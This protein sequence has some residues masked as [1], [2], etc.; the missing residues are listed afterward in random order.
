MPTTT[1]IL[2]FIS[3]F[4]AVSTLMCIMCIK[5]NQ[6]RISEDRR[7]YQ[8]HI[9]DLTAAL[10]P[11]HNNHISTNPTVPDTQPSDIQYTEV[12]KR[13]MV[14]DIRTYFNQRKNNAAIAKIP[15]PD[16][17]APVN[18]YTHAGSYDERTLYYL[19][20]GS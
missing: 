9:A 18:P 7:Q 5:R 12:E 17:L 11:T 2:I 6:Q 8:Q 10:F 1:H 20:R 4:L 15:G 13:K 14:A 19:E 16:E 3:S